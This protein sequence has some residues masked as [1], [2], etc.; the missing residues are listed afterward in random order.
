[1]GCA[2]AALRGACTPDP[3]GECYAPAPGPWGGGKKQSG[4]TKL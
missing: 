4:A 3:G 2:S 1:M